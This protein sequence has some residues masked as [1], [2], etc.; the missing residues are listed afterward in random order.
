[1]PQQTQTLQ[2]QQ[3]HGVKTVQGAVTRPTQQTVITTQQQTQ[4]IATRPAPQTIITQQQPLTTITQ[5]QTQTQAQVQ[6]PQ[7]IITQQIGQVRPG[8][9]VR[10]VSPVQARVQTPERTQFQPAPI[11]NVPIQRKTPVPQ[12]VTA[13][14]SMPAPG[15]GA[16]SLGGTQFKQPP[17]VIQTNQA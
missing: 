5:T 3:I 14:V 7:Q 1:M 8:S 4:G 9:Q 17:Q 12:N 16:A 11:Q 15:L 13:P 2:T 10:S 6:R